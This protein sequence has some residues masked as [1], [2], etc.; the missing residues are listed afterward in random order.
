MRESA[1]I[2]DTPEHSWADATSR[3]TMRVAC[4]RVED[5]VAL[6]IVVLGVVV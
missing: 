5:F 2:V 4:Q 1:T 3:L 6:G